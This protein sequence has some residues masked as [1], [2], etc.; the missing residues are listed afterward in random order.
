MEFIVLTNVKQKKELQYSLMKSRQL[1]KLNSVGDYLTYVAI[2]VACILGLITTVLTLISAL[3]MSFSISDGR[4]I[5]I[6]LLVLL[7]CYLF[8]DRIELK[9]RECYYGLEED[10]ILT[11]IQEDNEQNK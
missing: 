4:A 9:A 2:M 6:I 1:K 11:I 7:I 10:I 5:V 3:E 8:F